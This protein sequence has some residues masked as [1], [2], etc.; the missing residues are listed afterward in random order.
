MRHAFLVGAVVVGVV[1]FGFGCQH[2]LRDC[3][4]DITAID[5]ATEVPFD[6]VRVYSTYVNPFQNPS[7][8]RRF[9]G[10]TDENGKFRMWTGCDALDIIDVEKEGYQPARREV[11]GGGDLLFALEKVSP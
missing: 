11:H 10:L 6:S 4:I 9:V 1:L 2:I 3:A 8:A 5:A 7:Q